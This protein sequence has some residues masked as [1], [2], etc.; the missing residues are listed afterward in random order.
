VLS[1]RH[2]GTLGESYQTQTPESLT[3]THHAKRG[4]GCLAARPLAPGA[5]TADLG[6]AALSR[7]IGSLFCRAAVPT[8][9]ES[10][11]PDRSR[12]LVLGEF[13]WL[14]ECQ[15]FAGPI[16]ECASVQTILPGV[17]SL[18]WFLQSAVG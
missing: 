13:S 2:N 16:S 7:H 6:S 15:Q 12:S 8:R 10:D 9:R 4:S 17:V 5:M 18:R 14:I 11:V 3:L 1:H